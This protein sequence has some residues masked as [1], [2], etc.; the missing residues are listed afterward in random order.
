MAILHRIA[1]S[2]KVRRCIE[3]QRSIIIILTLVHPFATSWHFPSREN[4]KFR[5]AFL[6]SPER[7]ELPDRA[8]D[9]A[10]KFFKNFSLSGGLKIEPSA[11]LIVEG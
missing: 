8:E 10:E 9:R 4:E 5:G 6:L 2:G 1:K 11:I 3:Q 7:K